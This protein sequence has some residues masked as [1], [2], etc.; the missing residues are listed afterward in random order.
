MGELITV[1]IM[2]SMP[3]TIGLVLA[4]SGTVV[5]ILLNS[6]FV[7]LR[8]RWLAWRLSDYYQSVEGNNRKGKDRRCRVDRRLYQQDRRQTVL[9]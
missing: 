6:V 4:M 1:L 5:Y 8:T 9:I 3:V 7:S 2:L